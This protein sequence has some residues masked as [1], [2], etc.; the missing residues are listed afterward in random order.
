MRSLTLAVAA[1]ALCGTAGSAPAPVSVST[2]RVMRIDGAYVNCINFTNTSDRTIVAVNF[3]FSHVDVF[4]DPQGKVMVSRTGTFSPNVPIEGPT[5]NVI[6]ERTKKNCWR[7]AIESFSLGTATVRVTNVRFADGTEW[8]NPSDGEAAA[9]TPID[10][11]ALGLP[12]DMQQVGLSR[13]KPCH[14]ST[15]ENAAGSAQIWHYACPPDNA[16]K[17]TDRYYFVNGKLVQHL[18]D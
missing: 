16:T 9:R 8:T 7:E 5:P 13:G 14:V 10:Y 11:T 18:V 1:F 12:A 15:A 6:T 4:G 17:G 2:L 3:V